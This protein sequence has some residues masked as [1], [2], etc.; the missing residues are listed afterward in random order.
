LNLT[1]LFLRRTRMG[2]EHDQGCHHLEATA[3]VVAGVLGWNQQRTREEV[4]AYRAFLGHTYP[5]GRED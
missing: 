2:Y 5:N 3:E 1:D 4:E